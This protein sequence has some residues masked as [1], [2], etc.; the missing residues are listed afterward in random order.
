MSELIL[1][2]DSQVN[3]KSMSMGEDNHRAWAIHCCQSPSM[4]WDVKNF[5]SAHNCAVLL[6]PNQTLCN[7]F[8][9]G[10]FACFFY[11]YR[12][13]FFKNSFRNINAVS[14][15]LHPVTPTSNQASR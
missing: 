8:M 5:I 12:F 9:F 15:S 11:V 6:Y 13:N 4:E 7:F 14:N 3:K 2:G 1:E 10:N